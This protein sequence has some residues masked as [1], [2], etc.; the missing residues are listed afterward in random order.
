LDRLLCGVLTPLVVICPDRHDVGDLSARFPFPSFHRSA[1][2]VSS[3]GMGVPFTWMLHLPTCYS[4]AGPP[5]NQK[6]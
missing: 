4:P 1:A 5:A 3:R 2:A 6:V